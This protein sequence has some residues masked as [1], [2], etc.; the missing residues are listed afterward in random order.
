MHQN[1]PYQCYDATASVK[2]S[3]LQKKLLPSWQFPVFTEMQIGARMHKNFKCRNTKR[4]CYLLHLG[5]RNKLWKIKQHGKQMWEQRIQYHAYNLGVKCTRVSTS[6]TTCRCCR[7]GKIR[8]LVR[9]C[10][11]MYSTSHDDKS[12]S[13]LAQCFRH[14]LSLPL[15]SV[16]LSHD[17]M[18]RCKCN[19]NG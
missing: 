19:V 6:L 16:H 10:L 3:S 9:A 14:L 1:S 18:G 7:P 15:L 12:A 4:S 11:R 8:F 13:L 17:H 2:T 5:M